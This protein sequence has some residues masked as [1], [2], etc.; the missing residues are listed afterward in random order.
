MRTDDSALLAMQNRIRFGNGTM[1]DH[2]TLCT[3]IVKP[4]NAL[5]SLNDPEWKKAAILECRNELRTQLNNMSVICMAQ[6]NNEQLVVCV[7]R[8][9]VHVDEVDKHRFVEFWLN[10]PDSKTEGLPGNLPLVRGEIR[11]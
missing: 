8:D 9:T 10:L 4:M 6:E 11:R 7:A 3:R 5:R 1:D 2:Q